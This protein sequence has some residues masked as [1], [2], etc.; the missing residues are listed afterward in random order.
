MNT[1]F[2]LISAL[3]LGAIAFQLWREY[4]KRRGIQEEFAK[5]L[6]ESVRKVLPHAKRSEND[7]LATHTYEGTWHD[8]L[9]QI[10]YITD[11]LATRKLPTLWLS[12]SILEPVPIKGVYDLMNRPAGLASFSNFHD[13]PFILTKPKGLYEQ[14]ELRSDYPDTPSA[15]LPQ[16]CLHFMREPAAK[17]F[18]ASPKGVRVV[19]TAAEADRVRYGVFRNAD[20]IEGAADPELIENL[21]E[22]LERIYDIL[23]QNAERTHD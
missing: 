23:N 1:T 6:R 19:W 11:T 16:A 3:L 9:I 2:L 18:I 10:R 4:R 20:F 21:F 8:K 13:L 22:D 17:E 12:C 14:S 15:L 7:S 5:A